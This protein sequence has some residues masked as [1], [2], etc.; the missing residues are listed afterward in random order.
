VTGNAG[1]LKLFSKFKFSDPGIFKNEI[2]NL[3]KK[4]LYLKQETTLIPTEGSGP[5]THYSQKIF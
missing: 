5:F 4:W 3:E 2:E 1:F